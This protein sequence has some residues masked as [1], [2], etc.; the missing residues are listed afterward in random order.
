MLDVTVPEPPE[1]QGVPL[2]IRLPLE[3]AAMQ[4]PLVSEP[5]TVPNLVVLPESVPQ[6][7]ALVPP[8]PDKRGCPAVP[9]VV[10]KL[11]L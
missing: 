7:I 4:L 1:P 11:K 3:S 8:A 10:G 6:V 2:S 5:V 9:T